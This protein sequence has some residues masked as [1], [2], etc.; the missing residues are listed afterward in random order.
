MEND[1]SKLIYYLSQK[2]ETSTDEQWSSDG[3]D[4]TKTVHNNKETY[5]YKTFYGEGVYLTKEENVS[6]VK[7]YEYQKNGYFGSTN[8]INE[9]THTQITLHMP[10]G[11]SFYT[12]MSYEDGLPMGSSI[13]QGKPSQ[14]VSHYTIEQIQQV[15]KGKITDLNTESNEIAN[16]DE[17]RKLAAIVDTSFPISKKNQDVRDACV[18]AMLWLNRRIQE[19]IEIDLY[20]EVKDGIP[21]IDHVIDF[22]ERIKYEDNE[23]YLVSNAITLTPTQYVQHLNLIRWY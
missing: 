12:T 6:N 8:L 16:Y 21:Q 11:N 14:Q 1:K 5:T 13:S 17:R 22:T 15:F 9:E 3:S 4:G 18:E 23:Y 10:L 19:E 7:E 2:T 20:C